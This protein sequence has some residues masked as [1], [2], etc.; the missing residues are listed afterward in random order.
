MSSVKDI[1]DSSSDEA[2]TEQDYEEETIC[3]FTTKAASVQL[4]D[5]E[6]PRKSRFA[7]RSAYA[8]HEMRSLTL[9]KTQSHCGAR[10]VHQTSQ[11]S[12]SQSP[13]KKS[14]LNGKQIRQKLAL[15]AWN[16]RRELDETA[17]EDTLKQRR[18]ALNAER[19]KQKGG[20]HDKEFF[21]CFLT[22]LEETL[23]QKI[24]KDNPDAVIPSP[25]Q[26]PGSASGYTNR[27]STSSN[28]SR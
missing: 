27:F 8:R 4:A 28:R 1:L 21:K 23:N 13:C 16:K 9:R 6:S 19:L 2:I 14:G 7:E 5:E 12:E 26:S 10:L 20:P 17:Q 22:Y 18:V 15:E 3:S 25:P 24:K 11:L